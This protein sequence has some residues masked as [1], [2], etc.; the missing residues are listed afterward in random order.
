MQTVPRV[1][2]VMAAY[3]AERY[4]DEA[5]ESVLKQTYTDFELLVVDDH[6]TDGMAA[7]LAIYAERDSRVRIL[8]NQKNKGQL[9]SLNRGILEARGEFVAIMDADDI[10]L[11]TRIQAQVEYL[12]AHPEIGVVG[13]LTDAFVDDPAITRPSGARADASWLD[14]VI[15]MA[16]P[17]MMVRR[18][19]YA[20]HGLYDQHPRFETVGD[21]ELQSRFASRGVKM[22]VIDEILLHYR[23]HPENMT[24]SRRRE[25]VGAVL[26]L[27]LRILFTYRRLLS[28]RGWRSFL[29]HFA[30]WSYLTL[31]LETLIPR[32][33]GKRLLPAK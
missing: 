22:A 29:R 10:C 25:Q 11:N 6:S 23:V 12:E 7:K 3:N 17:T 32:S 8:R 16:H 14:G 24:K 2:V 1:S 15:V 30:I 33:L 26:Y 28:R 9:G 27:N 18:E 13:C 20:E 5:V 19:L 21:H 4:I 31:K